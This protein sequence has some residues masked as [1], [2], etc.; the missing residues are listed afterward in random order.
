MMEEAGEV[1]AGEA[2]A[3][4]VVAWVGAATRVETS[5]WDALVVRAMGLELV[6][7]RGWRELVV[8]GRQCC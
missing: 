5:G 1:M 4:E 2:A 8:A 6:W 7:W 3:L